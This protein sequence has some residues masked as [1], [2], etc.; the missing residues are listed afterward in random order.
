MWQPGVWQLPY[1]WP[2]PRPG[3]SACPCLVRSFPAPILLKYVSMRV[4]PWVAR[5]VCSRV[6]QGVERDCKSRHLDCALTSLG[7]QRNAACCCS[8]WVAIKLSTR[9]LV[10]LPNEARVLFM[11]YEPKPARY[12]RQRPLQTARILALKALL[13]FSCWLV[14]HACLADHSLSATQYLHQC[15]R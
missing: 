14:P 8:T 6:K 4:T 9:K 7:F 11:K 2:G 5:A 1:V 12:G 15:C 13:K 3:L 10:R